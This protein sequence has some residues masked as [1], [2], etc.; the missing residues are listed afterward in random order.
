[1]TN[2]K[3]Y[4]GQIV[5]HQ[6]FDYRG[7][8]FGVDAVFSQS[9]TWYNAMAVSKPPKDQPWYH[10]LVDQAT[11]TTYV[12]ERNL[13]A[14]EEKNQITHPALGDYFDRYNGERYFIKGKRN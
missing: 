12:A 13:E 1:M 2:T 10:V 4:L 6:R 3:F 5:H 8:I 14:C 9:D 11:H 7:V